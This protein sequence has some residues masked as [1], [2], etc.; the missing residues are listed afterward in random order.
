[1]LLFYAGMYTTFYCN[2][3]YPPPPPAPPPHFNHKTNNEV[4][5]LCISS[6]CFSII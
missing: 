5:H 4:L 3:A 6:H 1:M 2:V